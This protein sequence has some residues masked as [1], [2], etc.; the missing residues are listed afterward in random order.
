MWRVMSN[1]CWNPRAAAGECAEAVL[2]ICSLALLSFMRAES[3]IDVP[4]IARLCVGFGTSPNADMFSV[5]TVVISSRFSVG[6]LYVLEAL[7]G[8]LAVTMIS[9]ASGIGAEANVRALTNMLATLESVSF[10]ESFLSRWASFK[11]WLM[12]VRD[13]QTCKPSDH[14]W[15]RFVLPS[16]PQLPNQEP[17]RPQQ[18]IMPDFFVM[19]HFGQRK[20]ILVEPST[21]SHLLN[22]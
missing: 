17:P 19:P 4:A 15:S 5:T 7:T 8:A 21:C 12:A 13:L 10:E 22:A 9:R 16:L 6:A 20:S 18:L 11:C 3:V 1:T 14:V 2:N